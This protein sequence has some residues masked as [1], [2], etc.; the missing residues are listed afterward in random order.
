MSPKKTKEDI[1]ARKR[2]LMDRPGRTSV[3]GWI[4]EQLKSRIEQFTEQYPT[5]SESALVAAAVEDYL[6]TAERTGID[7]NY[8]PKRKREQ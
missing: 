5:L 4:T 8:K 6:E 3:T 7:V 2:K 1:M